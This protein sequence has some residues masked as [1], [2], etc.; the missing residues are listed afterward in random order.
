MKE[1]ALMGCKLEPGDLPLGEISEKYKNEM[2]GH[3]AKLLMK[4]HGF[5][6]TDI[7]CEDCFWK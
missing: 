6:A 7:F 4:E 3:Q 1:C 2:A 5:K